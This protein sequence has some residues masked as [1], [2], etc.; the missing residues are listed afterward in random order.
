MLSFTD[1]EHRDTYKGLLIASV[2][3][4]F[5]TTILSLTLILLLMF[6]SLAH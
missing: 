5:L 2:S 1:S 3:K 6:K 4:S